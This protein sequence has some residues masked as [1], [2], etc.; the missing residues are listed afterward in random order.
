MTKDLCFCDE[1]G[2]ADDHRSEPER[3]KEEFLDSLSQ[4]ETP[5]QVIH[6]KPKDTLH[7]R[8]LIEEEIK[9]KYKELDELLEQI[10]DAKR[11]RRRRR[12]YQL[13]KYD[14]NGDGSDDWGPSYVNIQPIKRRKRS[15]QPIRNAVL[16]RSAMKNACK[17]I[18]GSC[19]GK[20]CWAKWQ[21]VNLG[22][23]ISDYE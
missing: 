23:V 13:R 15:A 3:D 7:E 9:R 10:N 21:W 4:T 1:I 19:C 22:H 8:F 11:L 5:L 14:K 12:K 16:M 6:E 2:F 17:G 20:G 18:L